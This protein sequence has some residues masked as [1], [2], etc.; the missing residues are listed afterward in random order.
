MLK[1]GDGFRHDDLLLGRREEYPR[2]LFARFAM[3]M[4]EA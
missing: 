1:L 4:N 3:W 2:R